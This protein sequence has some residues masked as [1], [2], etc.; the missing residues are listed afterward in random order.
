MD[1]GSSIS[2]IVL[3]HNNNHFSKCIHSIIKQFL[4]P[5]DEIII[6]NDHSSN[7]YES[8]LKTLMSYKCIRIYN[9]IEKTGN[10]SHNRNIGAKY[11]KNPILMFIDG[12]IY[13]PQ[14]ILKYMREA[15]ILRNAVASFGNVYGHN[16][17]ETTLNALLGYDYL[18]CLFSKKGWKKLLDVPFM[19][20][21]RMKK[22]PILLSGKWAWNYFYTSYCMINK[23][24]FFKAGMFDE[25]FSEWGAE[26]VDLGFRLSKHG[27]LEYNQSLVAFHIPHQKNKIKNQINNFKNMYYM[28]SKY[29]SLEF[30]IKIAYDKSVYMLNALEEFLTYQRSIEINCQEFPKQVNTLY[31]DVVSKSSPNGKVQFIDKEGNLHSMELLGLALPFSNKTFITAY[32]PYE[33]FLY[34]HTL[35]PRIFQEFLRVSKNVY[36]KK[37]NLPKRNAWN[38]S[39]INGFSKNSPF[40]DLY[41]V[42][43][44]LQDFCLSDMGDIIQIKAAFDFYKPGRDLF[45]EF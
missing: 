40:R 6:I 8:E 32:I 38:S 24:V 41:F 9:S 20:D 35:I 15:L 7:E 39:I 28:L 5:D 31:Y 18:S 11:S 36:I 21:F 34:P 26:D 42:S 29:Q 43:K 23:D 1:S 19:I 3:F 25:A 37:H 4:T 22:D 27:V 30:E 17:D 12:D 2:I 33:I 44:T 16:Y 10:R 45:Y 14:P 13:F